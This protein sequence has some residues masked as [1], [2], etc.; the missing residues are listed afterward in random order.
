MKVTTRNVTV[1]YVAHVLYCIVV[2]GVI[3]ERRSL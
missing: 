1:L 2:V 3:R